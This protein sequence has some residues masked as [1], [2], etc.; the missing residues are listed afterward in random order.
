MEETVLA[1]TDDV[2]KTIHTHH[3]RFIPEWVAEVSQIFL[4]D[5]HVLPK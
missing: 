2:V 3:L 4:R 1:E 5:T